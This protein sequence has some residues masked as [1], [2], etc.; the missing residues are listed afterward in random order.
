MQHVSVQRLVKHVLAATNTH[1]TIGERCFLWCP[2]LIKPFTHPNPVYSHTLL[3]VPVFYVE[4]KRK[5]FQPWPEIQICLTRLNK[6]MKNL[7]GYDEI[8]IRRIIYTNQKNYSWAFYRRSAKILVY[9]TADFSDIPCTL[10]IHLLHSLRQW[11]TRGGKFSKSYVKSELH[12]VS[13]TRAASSK[14]SYFV[15]ILRSVQS[16]TSHNGNTAPDLKK[17]SSV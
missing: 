13:L 4:E 17:E 16:N 14:E 9:V 7:S 10:F 3:H 15:Q 8:W 2:C 11:V 6:I 5:I 1:V 12:Y